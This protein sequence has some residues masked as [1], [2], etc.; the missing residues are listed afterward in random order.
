MKEER[1]C[2]RLTRF[3]PLPGNHVA[4]LRPTAEGVNRRRNFGGIE[5]IIRGRHSLQSLFTPTD[6]ALVAWASH[7]ISPHK[8]S[9]QTPHPISSHT[10]NK[11]RPIFVPGWPA[12]HN[13]YRL[14]NQVRSQC[15]QR[16]KPAGMLKRMSLS[17]QQDRENGQVHLPESGLTH[18]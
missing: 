1:Y 15:D 14:Q 16:E 17:L 5:L 8:H 7:L 9:K 13:G 3:A 2:N 6:W 12:R 11:E 18:R 4:C 10:N